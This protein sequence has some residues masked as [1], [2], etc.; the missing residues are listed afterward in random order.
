MIKEKHVAI[1]R[2]T[3]QCGGQKGLADYLGVSQSTVSK[4]LN[5]QV[6]IKKN[7]VDKIVKNL[8][9]FSE[10]DFKDILRPPEEDPVVPDLD[11]KIRN[12]LASQKVPCAINV[13]KKEVCAPY[14]TVYRALYRMRKEIER[15]YMRRKDNLKTHFFYKLKS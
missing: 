5:G 6:T 1:W 8:K 12:F 14:Y 11:A 13:I 15:V 2:A 3:L 9:N 4:W 10:D 7:Y